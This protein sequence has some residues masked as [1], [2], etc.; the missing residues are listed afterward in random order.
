MKGFN[1]R[2]KLLSAKDRVTGAL[3]LG[4]VAIDAAA[5]NA[6]DAATGI[7]TAAQEKVSGIKTAVTE[8]VGQTVGT[9]KDK[10]SEKLGQLGEAIDTRASKVSAAASEFGAAA[11]RRLGSK[12]VVVAAPAIVAEKPKA[13]KITANKRKPAAKKPR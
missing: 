6:I 4:V 13:K 8:K 12:P 3:A 11:K 7:T 9:V 10:T 1:L 5:G 2:A